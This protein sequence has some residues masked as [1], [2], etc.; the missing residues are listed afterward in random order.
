MTLTGQTC[1]FFDDNLYRK[2]K[3]LSPEPPGA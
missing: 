3:A 2:G 1:P